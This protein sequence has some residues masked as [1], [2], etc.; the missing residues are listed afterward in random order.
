MKCARGRQTKP[1]PFGSVAPLLAAGDKRL[2]YDEHRSRRTVPARVF[3]SFPPVPP[4]PP[5]VSLVHANL[6][7]LFPPE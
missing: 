3:L 4:A 2:G 6:P 5:L 7:L 1:R